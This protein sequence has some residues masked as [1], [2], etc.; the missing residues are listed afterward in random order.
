MVLPDRAEVN[1]LRRHMTGECEHHYNCDCFH[2]SILL[3]NDQSSGTA[4]ERDAERNNDR[5]IS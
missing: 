5:Q 2:K 4:A 3:S 1:D